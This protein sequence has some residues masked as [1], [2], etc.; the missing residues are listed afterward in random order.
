MSYLKC[1]SNALRDGEMT[2]DAADAHR[3]EFQKQYDKFKSQ[4]YNDFEAERAAAKETWDVQ[5]EKRIRS[6]RNALYQARVQAQNK[7]TAENYKNVKGEKDIIEGIRSIFDQDAGNQILSI[8]NMK[9]TELGLVHAPLAKFM[10]KY[11]TSYFGRRNKF[12]KMTTPLIIKEILEPGSTAN[13]LAKEFAAAINEAIELARTR[14]NQFGGNVA[15]IK[16]NYLPQPH[17]PVKVGQATQEEWIEYILPKLD[18]ERMINNKTGRSFTREE[19]VLELPRT[20][21]AIR[22]EGV[23]QLVPGTRSTSRTMS[24]ASGMTANKRLDHRFLVFKSADDYMA[25]QSKFGDEDVISTIYQHLESISRDT[26]MMRALGPNPN[27]GFRYLVDLIR[28]NTKDMP[29]KERENIRAKIEG[30]ENLYLAHSGRLNSGVDKWWAM[31]FAGLRHILTSAV[32][33]SATLLAQSDFFFSRMTSKFLGLPAYKANRKALKLIKDG[34]KTDKTWSKAAIRAGLVGEHWST[35]ASAANRYFIDTDA[36]ILAKMLSDAT[37]RA[38]GLSHLT[39]AGRWA[40]GMEFMGFL[41]DNFNLSWKELNA[42]TQKGKLQSYGRSLTQTLETY[43]IRE[44]DWDLIRQTKLYDAAI[45]DPNIKPGEAMFF[46]PEDLLKRK[47]IDVGTANRLHARIMEM[48]FT[49]T[50]HAIPTAAIRGRVAVMGKNKPGTFAGEILASGLMFKNFAIAIGFT[51][52]MRGLRE[53]GLKGKAGYLVPFLIGTTLMNA[54]SHE[55]R[56]V[57]KGRDVINFSSLDKTQMFQYWLA[58][59]IGGGGLGIF[60]DLVY[61]E[62]EGENYGTDVTDALLGLPVAFAKDVYGLIDETLRYMPGGKEPALGREF[63]NFIKK[64]TPGSSIWYLRAA[65]ERIIVDTLQN[66]IDPKF[67]KRNNN[68]IKRYQNKE[69]R[70]YWWYPGE[71]MPSDAPE[72]S[73]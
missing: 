20:Y 18:L 47:D 22:T 45:D 10:E 6:K 3:I 19:L 2:S 25:Y 16:G 32:I 73:Q 8:T 52:I 55:M 24:N 60:G 42:L 66:L 33:G 40:F 36:P 59:L 48:I 31:G 9:R 37:L 30:L 28:V 11:R 46:K 63:S 38:S 14:H 21:E 72:I 69:N 49:E 61:Q 56:E 17:N 23:S 70:D 7:F 44:G 57:L 12:Q 43:G 26:A 65:W 68:I 35:I 50:D 71:N 41:G 62:A 29:I 34:L 13:P 67:H 15:K 27:A 54:Y 58:R 4:G 51:H 5:Q 64:Y 39:Q 53:T 1:I